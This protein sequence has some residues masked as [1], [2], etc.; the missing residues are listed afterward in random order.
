M[1]YGRKRKKEIGEIMNRIA[2]FIDGGYFGKLCTK[3]FR[4]SDGSTSINY[5]KFVQWISDSSE[6]LRAYYY[7][8][9]PYQ[10]PKPSRKER[11]MLSKR[12]KF[13][14]ALDKIP[15][16]C[17]RQG[18]LVF[19]GYDNKRKPIFFQKRVDL[20][21]GL[22]L[23][24]LVSAGK[25]EEVAIVAG[26]SDFIPAIEFAKREGVVVWLIHGPFGTYHQDLWLVADERKEITQK[27]VSS[28]C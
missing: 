26:D 7:D 8:C 25:V 27:I 24:S 1:K 21:L 14:F 19:R 2:I 5:E 22:D 18:K 9:L 13:F 23:G 28:F 10:L 16:F 3:H 12:Q 20:R 15:R 4:V 6:I 17:V 11:E